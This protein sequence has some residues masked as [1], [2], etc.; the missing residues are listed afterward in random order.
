ML[1]PGRRRA[2]VRLAATIATAALL[3]SACGSSSDDDGG[4][5]SG[6][7]DGAESFGEISLQYSWIKNEEF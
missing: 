2:G 3:L 5:G 6:S 4:S 1:F 7:G